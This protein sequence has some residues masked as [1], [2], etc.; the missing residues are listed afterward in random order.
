MLFALALGFAFANVD[1][2]S[3]TDCPSA[4]SV[5]AQLESLSLDSTQPRRDRAVIRVLG[6]SVQLELR[7]EHDSLV[8]TRTLPLASC[9]ELARTIAIL[10]S[11]WQSEFG[12][13]SAA[14][15]PAITRHPRLRQ[16]FDIAA[17][18]IVPVAL[19]SGATSV[20]GSLEAAIGAGHFFGRAAVGA[21]S[22][23]DIPVGAGEARFLRA[24]LSLGPLIRFVPGRFILDLHA[25]ALFALLYVKGQGFMSSPT[26]LG[27]DFGIG[28]GFR[29]AWHFSKVA[30][31]LGVDL[32][33]W[34]LSQR[35]HTTGVI[36]TSSLPTFDLLL[37]IGVAFGRF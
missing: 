37:S 12:R 18:L 16:R 19:P 9:D 27:F 10:I 34:P 31:F 21:S 3:S 2:Q 29:A 11:S 14:H 25:E 22:L 4:Q 23:R 30:P 33:G 5:N 28:A 17:S 35:V 1:V 36:A 13:A 20:G 7:D 32:N 6:E 15:V 8:A 26:N 24:D